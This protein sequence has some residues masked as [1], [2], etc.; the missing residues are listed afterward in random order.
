MNYA[1]ITGWGHYLPEKV[2]TNRELEAAVGTS[3]EWI[4]TRTGIRERR[5]AG[6]GEA[7]ASMCI[8]AAQRALASAEL[9]GA[10]LDLVICATTT[11]DHLLPPTACIV[12]QG[13]GATRAG[14]FDLNS[15][16]TGFLYGLVM[17]SQFIQAGTYRRV[18]VVAG[19]TLSRF[20]DWQDRRTCVLF[21]DGAGAVVLEATEQPSGPLGSVLGCHGDVEHLLAIEG[22]GSAKPASVATVEAGEHYLTMRGHEVFKF[23]VRSMI[24]AAGEA[25][26]RADRTFTDLR[27]VIP[28]Q[29]NVRILKASQEALALPWE[30][31][32]VNVD[33][34]GNTGAASVP[35]ALSEYLTTGAVQPGDNLLLVAF[36]GGLT[37]AATVVGWAD[38]PAII[39]RR[40]K[41]S[42]LSKERQRQGLLV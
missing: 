35:I 19:E 25:L 36:G 24:Q 15:A 21:G 18:L 13:L 42:A 23:A 4:R 7:T 31:F 14:A 16:C 34:Y 26:A 2:L 28:H 10:D 33:R 40:D 41:E 22:G 1:A 38:V 9:S 39:A 8:T 5:I 6:P 3:D 11:P 27:M 12:Q 20:V 37:W 17:G 29:A 32:F 30:K